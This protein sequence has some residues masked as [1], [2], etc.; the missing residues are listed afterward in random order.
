[1]I[2]T[3]SLLAALALSALAL[4]GGCGAPAADT[5]VQTNGAA[6]KTGALSPEDAAKIKADG[7]KKHPN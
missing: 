1:M 7:D 3:I 2:K 5:S 4:L 6:L